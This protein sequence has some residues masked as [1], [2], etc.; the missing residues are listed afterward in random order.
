MRSPLMEPRYCHGSI[1]MIKNP[2]SGLPI[3]VAW[4]SIIRRRQLFPSQRAD[5]VNFP[6]AGRKSNDLLSSH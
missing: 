2:N 3:G 1:Q 5:R 4:I 6:P